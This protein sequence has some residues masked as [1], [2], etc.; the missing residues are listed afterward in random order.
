MPATAPS[1]PAGGDD[2]DDAPLLAAARRGD[3]AAFG[4]LVMRYQSSVRRQLRH[5]VRGSDAIA[6][7]LAQDSFVLA[8]RQIGAFRGEA[9]FS[10]WL[11]RIAYRRFLMHVRS[12]SSGVKVI[13]PSDSDEPM[14]EV[15]GTANIDIDVARRLDVARAMARL[16]DVQ[17]L[18]LFH[19]FEL[20]LTHEEA[21]LV[22]GMPV[23]T[24]KSHVA[25]GKARLREDLAAWAPVR[26]E[27]A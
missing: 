15:A 11:H 25:R 14:A 22:L 13:A 19:C 2:D 7:E 6:D 5:L 21:A 16:P 23:G 4:A 17:Q 24:L 1:E 27:H 3:G 12:E 10:T 20:D 8:W 26:P 18:A 9:R